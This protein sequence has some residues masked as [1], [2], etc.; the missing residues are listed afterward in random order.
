MKESE[1]NNL[2]YARRMM[3]H[4][5]A[6]MV[7]LFKSMTSSTGPSFFETDHSLEAYRGSQGCSLEYQTVLSQQS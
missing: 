5:D 1:S 6:H 2:A 3:I 7:S 4:R